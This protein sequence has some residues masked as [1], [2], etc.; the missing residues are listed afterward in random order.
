LLPNFTIKT[1]A[2]TKDESDKLFK[3]ALINND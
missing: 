3:R 1:K 2:N